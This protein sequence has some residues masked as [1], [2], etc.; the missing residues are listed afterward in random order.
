MESCVYQ[1]N[2]SKEYGAHYPNKT[3]DCYKALQRSN[4]KIRDPWFLDG[5]T[6]AIHAVLN[7]SRIRNDPDFRLYILGYANLFND[8][9]KACDN[10]TFG[11]WSGKTEYLTRALRKEINRITGAGRNLYDRYI[12]HQLRD[13]RVKFLDIDPAFKGHRFCEP[14]KEGTQAAQIEKSWLWSLLWPSCI[15]LAFTDSEMEA[16]H[17]L[18]DVSQDDVHAEAWPS[19]CR[20]CGGW[21]DLGELQRPF[22]PKWEGHN[23]IKELL[24]DQ[25]VQDNKHRRRRSNK[26]LPHT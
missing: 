9:D 20:K 12:N 21:V 8:Q 5:I 7:E 25:I 6:D 23:A 13:P 10:Q 16:P 17:Q 2:R 24:M 15:P 26:I 11:I 14:T 18:L 4:K 19:F 3:G 1:F 22:H